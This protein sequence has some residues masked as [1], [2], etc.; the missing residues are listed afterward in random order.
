MTFRRSSFA[1]LFRFST[2][3]LALACGGEADPLSTDT[4]NPPVIVGQNL[5]VAAT[6][7]GVRVTGS[8]GT[9]PRGA[10]VEVVNLSTGESATTTAADDGSFDVELEGSVADGYR[11]YSDLDGKTSSAHLSSGGATDAQAG[12]A[13]LDFLL[14]SAQGYTPVEGTGVRVSFS[15][16]DISISAACNSQFGSYSLCDGR[17]CV[18]DLGRTEIGCEPALL[19]QDDWFATFFTSSPL[20]TQ[21]GARLVLE[22]TDATLT[23]LDREVAD[24]DR[25]LV[26][27]TWT[28]DTM[29][30]G[31]GPSAAASPILDLA[32]LEFQPDGQLAVFVGCLNGSGA[33]T[34]GNGTLT[35]SGVTFSPAPCMPGADQRV[36]DHIRQVLAPGDVSFAIDARRLTLTRTD[37]GLAAVAD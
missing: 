15:D 29:V 10:R 17:L 32:T 11:V 23:F 6:D 12:L 28:V 27:P 14:E 8:A 24:P 25:P 5:L 7:T 3:A 4:G 21:T 18:S 22:G 16:A 34:V 2:L 37:V 30:R 13:G 35:F 33:Y 36:I 1:S 26:G 20:V 31:N 9:V 19:A